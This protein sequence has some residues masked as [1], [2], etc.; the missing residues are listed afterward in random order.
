MNEQQKQ[1]DFI[2]DNRDAIKAFT[3]QALIKKYNKVT[4]G[5]AKK[6]DAAN[7]L[8]SLLSLELEAAKNE[9]L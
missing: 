4:M 1:F 3:D 8:I 7:G 5:L 9:Q 6:L 2:S